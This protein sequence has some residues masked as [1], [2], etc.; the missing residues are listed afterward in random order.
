MD[1][2]ERTVCAAGLGILLAACAST[3]PPEYSKTHPANPEAPA[4]SAPFAPSSL[5]TYRSFGN[6]S[7]ASDDAADHPTIESDHAH[8]H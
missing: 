2:I 1:L 4:A 5:A 7:K 8:R 6:Q 3:P